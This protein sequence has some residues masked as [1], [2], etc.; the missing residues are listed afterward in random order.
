MSVSS[1]LMSASYAADGISKNFAFPRY[2][3]NQTDLVVTYTDA[4]SVVT[5]KVLG[6]DYTIS[7]IVDSSLGAYTNGGTIQFAVAPIAGGT[8]NI[9]RNTSVLQIVVYQE[10]DPF[11]AKSHEAALDRAYLAI[12]ELKKSGFT[13][14]PSIVQTIL[15]NAVVAD[16]LRFNAN[17]RLVV[18][19]P[20]ITSL[21]GPLCGTGT[22]T[23]SITS[24]LKALT[25]S[26]ASDFVNGQY[27]KVPHAGAAC[28]CVAP[29]GLAVASSKWDNSGSINADGTGATTIAYKVVAL[30]G[31]GGKS[32]PTAAVQIT[33]SLAS[34]MLT[35]D[36]FNSL[37]WNHSTN[38]AAYAIYRSVSGGAYALVAVVPDNNGTQPFNPFWYDM[39]KTNAVDE[40]GTLPPAGAMNQD[41]LT[42]ITAGGGTT[43]VTVA[44]AA[45]VTVSG[46]TVRHDD[47]PAIN[48]AT[49]LVA[50]Q[51]PGIPS[52]LLLPAGAYTICQKLRA[53]FA[54][55]IAVRGHLSDM[56][57]GTNTG[58]AVLN[59]RGPLGG[60]AFLVNRTQNSIFERLVIRCLNT[61][62]VAI[63][64]DEVSGSSPSQH[65]CDFNK[66][67][68]CDSYGYG[69]R[70]GNAAPDNCSENRLNGCTF[71]P[72]SGAIANIVIN[73]ANA[74]FEYI[75]QANFNGG[76]IWDIYCNRGSFYTIGTNFNSPV[77]VYINSPSDTIMLLH[78]Q[79]ETFT[80]RLLHTAAAGSSGPIKVE[81]C[82][83]NPSGVALD[84]AFIIYQFNGVL[85]LDDND[86]TD[87][88]TSATWGVTVTG[89]QNHG[90]T[91]VVSIGNT[92]PNATPFAQPGTLQAAN[93]PSYV[94]IGDIFRTVS[95][96]PVVS[97]IPTRLSKLATRT[98]SIGTKNADF[99]LDL[100]FYKTLLTLGSAN[101]TITLP[102]GITGDRI[103]VTIRQHASAA[104]TVTW[105]G[106]SA[107][108]AAPAMTATLN[109]YQT[110]NFYCEDFAGAWVYEGG[111]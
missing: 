52:E 34:N 57:N 56:N 89:S 5:T 65:A 92:Y 79:S 88:G 62:A 37:T 90:I 69:V 44:D 95:G 76:A 75:D 108:G 21:Y 96:T 25:L 60:T 41:L 87:G 110:F 82:R 100:G 61:P 83:C 101:I 78:C 16:G 19:A 63:E 58:G 22:P 107:D 54:S 98:N 66:I 64:V 86:F 9:V 8:V 11:P 48:Y 33:N 14:T 27:I 36:S 106:A 71:L 68:I 74:K 7:G 84:G 39:G 85:H 47:A 55:G 93:G 24:G 111:A 73:N 53:D 4:L 99:S 40:D 50:A 43:S 20:S 1:E 28:A 49:G 26:A 12:Q 94:S 15:A 97:P 10:G 29:A 51:T 2:F 18:T 77:G 109:K 72:S 45:G 6:V 91:P 17:G 105:S 13:P 46:V 80:K 3:I 67:R 35:F 42:H 31:L 32:A 38:A 59:Y 102:A 81:N 30:D 103:S 23:G 70:I 104:K